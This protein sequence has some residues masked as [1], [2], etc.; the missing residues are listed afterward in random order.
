M[1][2]DIKR[3]VEKLGMSP[4]LDSH[5]IKEVCSSEINFSERPLYNWAYYLIPEGTIFPL[6]KLLSDESW[7]FCLG[8]PLD[9]FILKEGG[10]E[11]IRIGN[12]IFDNENLFY[13]VKSNTWFAAKCAPGTKF[14]LIMHCVSPGW[15]LSDDIPGYY[16][17][18]INLS[19]KNFEFIKEYSC[20]RG[21]YIS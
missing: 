3:I 15:V 8:G 9:L 1:D 18:M 14:T 13:L 16:E 17:E 5:Y 6:H 4:L 11:T 12:N 19:P 20:P 7:N 21:Q 2:E 10:I